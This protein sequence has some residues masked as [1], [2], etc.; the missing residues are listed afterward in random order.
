MTEMKI[1]N[2]RWKVFH[3]V[4]LVCPLVCPLMIAAEAAGDST[5][6]PADSW[7]FAGQNLYNTRS[8]PA[9]H[10][11]GPRNVGSLTPRWVFTTHGDV[12]ATPSVQGDALYVPDWGGYL[13]KINAHTGQQVW[14][15]Q[16]SEYDGIPGAFSR[17]TPA[18]AAKKLIIGDQNGANVMAID[19][20][21]GALLW[22]TQ[23]DSHPAAIITQ[24]PVVDDGRV[25]VGVSSGEE[26]FAANPSYPCCSFR[27]S[28]LALDLD[29]GAILWKTYV[30]PPTYSGGAV[31]GSTP[32]VDLKRRSLYVTTGNNYS[33]PAPVAACVAAAGDNAAAADACLAPDDYID[34]VVALDLDTG[35]IKWGHRLQGYDVWTVA[36]LFGAL[37]PPLTS[38]DY[39]F[40]SGANL[41]TAGTGH[42]KRD[43]LG[44]GQKSGVYWALDPDTGHIVWGT[45]VGPGSTFGGIQWGSATDGQRIYVAIANFA[46]K[47]YTLTSGQTITWGAY[48]ALDAATGRILWQTADPAG[49][50]P[51]GAVTVAN[52]VLYAESI[53]SQGP[54]YAFNAATG[55]LLWSFESHG[56]AMAGAAVVNGTVYWGSGYPT[57]RFGN[58]LF[59]SGGNKLYA[60]G[61]SQP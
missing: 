6:A 16:I 55:D 3:V 60:F 17:T 24:S 53:A 1:T 22:K 42:H 12:S 56:S 7:L 34:A 40:G 49:S 57:G 44:A 54:L 46:R 38:P 18:I 15:H 43:L 28:E 2:V 31:W 11:L 8:A 33:V 29:T 23:V 61:R 13:F 45:S 47:S 14:A 26:G 36:C 37:C 21:T 50:F 48:S 58:P 20:D 10:I 9:E 30:V 51:L 35:R 5:P 32:V 19:K 4:L 39:D 27:G 52:G 41:F 59:S 25:Y